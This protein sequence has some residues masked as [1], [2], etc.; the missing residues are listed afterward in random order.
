MGNFSSC[1]TP[2]YTIAD[3]QQ[4]S[5]HILYSLSYWMAAT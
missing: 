5:S 4:H 2:D 3:N 1:G